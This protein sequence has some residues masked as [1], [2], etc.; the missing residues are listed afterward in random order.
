M[1]RTAPQVHTAEPEKYPL[2]AKRYAVLGL[3][4]L[5]SVLFWA[6][7]FIQAP[8]LVSFWGV[9]HHVAFGTAEYLMSAV[10]LA[11]IAT[12]LLAGHVFDRL[13]P[14]RAT[15]LCFAVVTVGFGLRPF[16]VNSFPLMM[17]LTVIAGLGGVPSMVAAPAVIAQWFG[18]HR[19]TFALS[20]SIASFATGQAIGLLVGAPMVDDLG[21]TWTFGTFSLALVVACL[22]WLLI[23]PE[24]PKQPAGPPTVG[25]TPMWVG[26]KEV[27]RAQGS[28]LI[29]VIAM[30]LGGVSV[31]S[32][33]L[34][35]SLLGASFSLSPSLAGDGSTA[36]PVLAIAGLFVLGFL[37]RRAH[38]VRGHGLWTSGV[39]LAC[40]LGFAISWWQHAVPLGAALFLIGVL[41]FFF[42]PC[43]SFAVDALEHAPGVRPATV[44]IASGFYFTGV[45]IGGY[46][47]PTVLAHFV[48]V[49]GNG[50]GVAGLLVMLGILAALWL[51][52]RALPSRAAE[53]APSAAPLSETA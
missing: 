24:G 17:V 33:S 21:P 50:A 9:R 31:F 7:W 25:R 23:V 30:F 34:F 39:L 32:L 52:V 11:G 3:W 15:L 13:G 4:W 47:L 5:G 42:Q 48:Q 8:I 10:N 6:S 38:D 36:M 35:P 46:V 45:G 27:A 51:A 22:A 43:F 20:I 53:N 26:L 14:R 12:A 40:W 16:A 49:Y 28:W 37:S 29:F 1:A 2:E 44:G 41:G 19:M 18:R